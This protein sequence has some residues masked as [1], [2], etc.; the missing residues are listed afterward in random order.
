MSDTQTMFL[1]GEELAALT[2]RQRSPSQGKVLNFM[3]IEHRRRPDG[4]IAVLRAHVERMMGEGA[5]MKKP[6]KKTEPRFD[7]VK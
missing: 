6:L 4:S 5:T 1:T 3:G 7:L 2:H